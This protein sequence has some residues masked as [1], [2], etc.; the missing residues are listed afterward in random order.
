MVA[1]VLL[2]VSF[3]YINIIHV[4]VATV[5][6]FI[7]LNT[8]YTQVKKLLMHVHIRVCCFS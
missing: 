2:Y 5:E 1:V 3:V 6:I 7:K 4:H 8:V